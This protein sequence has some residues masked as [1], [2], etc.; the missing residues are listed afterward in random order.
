M[1]NNL[2]HI[3]NDK[4]TDNIFC[5]FEPLVILRRL[6]YNKKYA[7]GSLYGGGIFPFWLYIKFFGKPVYKFCRRMGMTKYI[8]LT[9]AHTLGALAHVGFFI[10]FEPYKLLM[11]GASYAILPPIFWLLHKASK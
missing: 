2:A 7:N 6:L 4:T 5:R 11:F 10:T 8:S 1:E 9:F 3:T